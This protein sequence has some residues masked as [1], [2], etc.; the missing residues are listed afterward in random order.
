[1]VTYTTDELTGPSFVEALDRL[2][3]VAD[4][5]TDRFLAGNVSVWAGSKISDARYPDLGRLLTLLLD[6][7]H[8]LSA[9]V[10]DP[11][12]PERWTLDQII[13][14][15]GVTGGDPTVRFSDWDD[16]LKDA[17][18]DALWGEYS[19]VLGTRYAPAGKPPG[20]VGSLL[21]D[22]LH[23]DEIYDDPDVVPDAE[24]R[25]LALL[26]LEGVLTSLVTTNWDPLIEDAYGQATRHLPASSLKTVV[27][28]SDISG[29]GGQPSL[30][31]MHGCA[32]AAKHDPAAQ[33]YVVGTEQQ[34]N[35]WP[36][37]PEVQPVKDAVTNIARAFE[38]LYLGLSGQDLNIQQEHIEAGLFADWDYTADGPRVVFAHG[39]LEG[40]KGD[41]L[42]AAYGTAT[43]HAHY[44]EIRDHA[45]VPLFAKPLLGALYAYVLREKLR[46]Y[47]RALPDHPFA[48][49]AA[50]G[51]E[52]L[53]DHIAALVDDVP[54]STTS[55][56]EVRRWRFVSKEGAQFVSS[57]VRVYRNGGAVLDTW[58]YHALS[59]ASASAPQAS[60]YRLALAIGILVEGHNQS[61]WRLSL[62][63]D[64][65][66]QLLIH[67]PL[68]EEIP[69]F[70]T[71]D[72][73]VSAGPLT[74]TVPH[75]SETHLVLVAQGRDNGS[76]GVP[77]PTATHLARL[78]AAK[79]V[80]LYLDAWLDH[81]DPVAMLHAQLFENA[82]THA[83]PT[84]P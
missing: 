30:T 71:C 57:F 55:S 4:S 1:M 49:L 75:P 84:A 45:L 18:I 3:A 39:N 7:L 43:Y 69:V 70:V 25:L 41:I 13:E 37:K 47:A 82:L 54:A 51:V 63:P 19:K 48:W 36:T 26:I 23:I 6:T 42:E 61:R 72:E 44:D 83:P 68:G 80:E 62:V 40:P 9:N 52:A 66:E 32:R 60:D 46:A 11:A 16:T 10:A 27:R 65:P 31:K 34:V 67:T 74:Y 64:R 22:V 58:E 56:A 81:P 50:Q 14:R 77:S 33:V 5:F 53:F 73:M 29:T 21:W 15:S 20:E 8:D 24:H 78:N 28:P 79:R 76:R 12:D 59:A 38:V 17:V 2:A 35:A